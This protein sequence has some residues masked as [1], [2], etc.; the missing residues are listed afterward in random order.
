MHY[1][2]SNTYRIAAA[3]GSITSRIALIVEHFI[4]GMPFAVM[5]SL[6]LFLSKRVVVSFNLWLF[7]DSFAG[8]AEKGTVV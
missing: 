8:F 6:L 7:H 2:I 5:I 4:R 3:T 1:C